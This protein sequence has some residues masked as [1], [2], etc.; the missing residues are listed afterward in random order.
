MHAQLCPILWDTMECSPPDSYV[1][2]IFQAR[3]LEWAVVSSSGVSSW[4]RDQTHVSCM[5]YIGRY[6]FYHWPPGKPIQFSSV[7]QLCPMF[8]DPMHC[9]MPGLPGHTNSQSLLKLMSI[10]LVMPSNHLILCCPLLLPPS[11]FPSIRVFSNESLLHIRWKPIRQHKYPL[12]HMNFY[13][14]LMVFLCSVNLTVEKWQIYIC[15][16]YFFSSP[17]SPSPTMSTSPFSTSTPLFSSVQ[18]SSVAQLSLTLCNPMDHSTPGFP[19][20][21]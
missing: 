1:H 2:G 13:D 14:A 12:M 4:P 7:T 5:S 8:C 21:H 9:S 6:I 17:F 18:F 10:E 20:H 11:I 3:I 15:Q 16:C 19:V